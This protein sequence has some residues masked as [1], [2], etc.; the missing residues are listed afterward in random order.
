MDGRMGAIVNSI[1]SE[2]LRVQDAISEK[3]GNYIHYMSMFVTG[4]AVGFS[5][6]WKLVLVTLAVVPAIAITGS[7]HAAL[8]TGR[9]KSQQEYW[10]A[11]SI[12]EQTITQVRTVYSFVGEKQA[13]DS[14]SKAFQTTLKLGYKTGMEKG[15]AM[16]I[17]YGILFCH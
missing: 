1:C 15:L 2:N 14:Y 17:T 13:L 5:A 8:F 6:E 7:F 11:G 16:G 12:A 3:V 4:F 10:E 9:S